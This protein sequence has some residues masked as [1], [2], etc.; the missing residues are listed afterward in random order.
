[1][2][3]LKEIAMERKLSIDRCAFKSCL[4]NE[5][6]QYLSAADVAIIMREDIPTNNVASP[7]K[8]GEY[9]SCGLPIILTKGIGDYS[10]MVQKAKVGLLLDEDKNEVE[11]IANF[12]SNN[13]LLELREKAIALAREK[14]S[15]EAYLCDLKNLFDLKTL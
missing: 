10:E 7:I 1:M 14:I 8:I 13:N 15:W 6:S 9:L 2:E 5:I 3:K 12:L 11:Q 4:Q